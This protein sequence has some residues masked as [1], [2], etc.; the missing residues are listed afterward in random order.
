M[1]VFPEE[2]SS[3]GFSLAKARYYWRAFLF[4][5]CVQEN[6]MFLLTMLCAWG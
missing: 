6:R 3:I 4:G 5:D 2:N 1:R